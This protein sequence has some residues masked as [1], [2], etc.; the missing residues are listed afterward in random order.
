MWLNPIS[1]FVKFVKCT[2]IKNRYYI[3]LRRNT[4]CRFKSLYIVFFVIW[5]Y[6]EDEKITFFVISNREVTIVA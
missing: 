5:T 2:K 4:I 1:Q 3:D 6:F